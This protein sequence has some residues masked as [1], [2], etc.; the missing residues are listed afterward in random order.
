MLLLTFMTMCSA[1]CSAW[2][3]K[4]PLSPLQIRIAPVQPGIT[5]AQ[6]KPGDIIELKITAVSFIDVQEMRIEVELIGGAK[7]VSGDM[8]WSGPASRNEEK[9]IV[10]TV[11]APEKGK[12]RINAR[13]S[14]PPSDSTRFSAETQYVLGP[15]DKSKPEHEHPVK[16]DSKGRNV[17]EYR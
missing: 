12:G 16:K 15:E 2:S 13:L 8:S 10:L 9:T 4:K 17:I 5:S 6:I 11:R 7:L 3:A 1:K 14:I